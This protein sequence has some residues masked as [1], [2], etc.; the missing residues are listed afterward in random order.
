MIRLSMWLLGILAL[1]LLAGL[2]TLAL[3]EDKPSD[4]TQQATETARGQITKVSADH[5]QFTLKDTNGREWTFR[6][7]RDNKVQFNGKETSLADLKAGDEVTVHYRL[8]AR[9][10]NS[11]AANRTTDITRG[12]ITKLSADQNQFTLKDPNGKEWMFQVTQ[13]AKVRVNDKEARL[14]DLKIG[15]DVTIF[16]EKQNDQLMARDIRSG[17][18]MQ[19][20]AFAQGQVAKV[21]DANRQ[22]IVKDRN[23]KERTFQVGQ[24]A[25]VRLNG[26]DSNLADLKA[27]NEVTVAYGMVAQDIRSE[28]RNP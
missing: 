22:L 2:P 15:D 5:H 4:Q 23:G 27:G 18:A 14:A 10:V 25:K 28:R 26:Q 17:P 6:S 19:A 3:A 16:Y 13:N 7:G 24:D 12:Q 20:L 8:L 21:S 9:N 11:A 1:A